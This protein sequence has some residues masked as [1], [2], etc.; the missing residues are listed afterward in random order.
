MKIYMRWCAALALAASLAGCAGTSP[1]Q[2][3]DSQG[4]RSGVTVFG[5]I[6]VGV[7]R[8]R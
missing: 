1:V 5:D 7:G 8:V 4:S 2:G 3:A 6:D